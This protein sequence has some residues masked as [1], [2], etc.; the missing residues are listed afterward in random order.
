MSRIEATGHFPLLATQSETPVVALAGSRKCTPLQM[1]ASSAWS[2][3]MADWRMA[4]R[5]SLALAEKTRD[6]APSRMALAVASAARMMAWTLA[7]GKTGWAERG[8]PHFRANTH[9]AV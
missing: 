9:C 3:Y 5:R 6:A 4:E 2:R 7:S 1:T 8:T